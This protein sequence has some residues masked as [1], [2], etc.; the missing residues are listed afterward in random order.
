MLFWRIMLWAAL[1]VTSYDMAHANPTLLRSW[2][3]A[4]IL[5]LIAI[6]LTT[7]EL[8]ERTTTRRGVCWPSPYRL[9]LGYLIVQI[10]V[11]LLLLHF[12]TSFLG[13]LFALMP[14]QAV[15]ARRFSLPQS[16]I[17]FARA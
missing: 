11:A 14:C 12:N 16:C 8:F 4:A 5:G 1:I 9:V 17:R 13:P 7:Y 2:R 3:G 15:R 6:F 10:G